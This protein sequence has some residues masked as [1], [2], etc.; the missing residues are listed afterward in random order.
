MSSSVQLGYPIEF[1]LICIAVGFGY[2][3]L[4]YKR[5]AP[6][7]TWINRML[8]GMRWILVSFLCVLLLSP[9]LRQIQNTTEKPSVILAVDNS[10]S[11]SA[12]YDSLETMAISEQINE[13]GSRLQDYGYDV[14]VVTLDGSDDVRF[15]VKTS[16]LSQ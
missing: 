11:V 13:L 16:N 6:W 7:S 10:S 4:L 8:F 14:D 5:D 2:A 15:S 9:V 1:L 12:V 3:F